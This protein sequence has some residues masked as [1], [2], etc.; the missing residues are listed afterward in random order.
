MMMAMIWRKE[1]STIME[2]ANSPQHSCSWTF[3]PE[4]WWCDEYLNI[5]RPSELHLNK[6]NKTLETSQ[7]CKQFCGCTVAPHGDLSVQAS[8]PCFTPQICVANSAATVACYDM[9]W[10]MFVANTAVVLSETLVSLWFINEGSAEAWRNCKLAMKSIWHCKCVV[11][12]LSTAS[13][14]DEPAKSTSRHLPKLP[15][16]WLTCASDEPQKPSCNMRRMLIVRFRMSKMI[17]PQ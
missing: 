17:D 14:I 6:L 1:T 13:D 9:W 4:A 10:L 3:S 15:R 12:L 11:N 8:P 5:I 7:F 16:R 2:S